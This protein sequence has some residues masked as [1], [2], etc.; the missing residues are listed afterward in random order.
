MQT[1][2]VVRDKNRLVAMT[3]HLEGVVLPIDVMEAP[4]LEGQIIRICSGMAELPDGT[5]LVLVDV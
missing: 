1:A 4:W 2:I 3:P 5:F